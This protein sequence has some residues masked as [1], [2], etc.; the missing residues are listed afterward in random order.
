[1]KAVA[2]NYDWLKVSRKSFA[3][4]LLIVLP[5]ALSQI[6]QRLFHVVDNRF[7]GQLGED[8]LLLHNV[9]YTFVVFGQLMG[10]AT[11]TSAL[12]FWSREESQSRKRS[13][14]N[15]HLMTSAGLGLGF[16]IL[17]ASL[18]TYIFGHFSVAPGLYANG[19]HLYF[20]I[21][22]TNMALQ[23]VYGT[24]DGFLIASGKQRVTF[25]LSAVQVILN[26][27]A[28]YTAVSYFHSTGRLDI[29]LMIVGIS[30]TLILLGTLVTGYRIVR[31]QATGESEMPMAT[32][33]PV[34]KAELLAGLLRACV[35]LVAAWSFARI[36]GSAHFLVTHNL[37]LHLSYLFCLP[38]L[39]AAQ[40]ATKDASANYRSHDWRAGLF[41]VGILPTTLL[42]IIAAA[43][44][45]PLIQWAYGFQVPSDHL[46]YLALFFIAC[47]I[48]QVANS[49]SVPLRAHKLSFLITRHF[50][51]AEYGVWL[52]GMALLAVYHRATPFAIG[53]VTILFAV[54][55]LILNL[56]SVVGL[57]GIRNTK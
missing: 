49:L 47:A 55:F 12:V 19:G 22:L 23:G 57:R 40:V 42:L 37:A 30:T 18:S 1:M 50:A 2:S 44:G 13:L 11:A 41:Y 54:S 56:R 26:A 5:V 38:L 3:T 17:F 51:I 7:V 8:A 35:P 45:G 24:V 27:A 6:L 34:L 36:E 25:A 21:G 9:Q 39:A 32:I 16:W 46:P 28:D 48:G 4:Q 14:L 52:G 53:V 10:A 15:R 20:L 31:N 43:I 29:A 33:F